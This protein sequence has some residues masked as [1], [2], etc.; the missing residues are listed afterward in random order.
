MCSGKLP[1][2]RWEKRH[3]WVSKHHESLGELENKVLIH[4]SI[5]LYELITENDNRAKGGVRPV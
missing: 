2:T 4:I 3:I 1:L 5:T